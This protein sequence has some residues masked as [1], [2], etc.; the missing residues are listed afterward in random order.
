LSAGPDSDAR[1]RVLR[2]TLLQRSSLWKAAADR[3]RRLIG[4]RPEDVADVTHL[5]DD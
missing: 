4:N 2:T 1:D 5:V 3:A